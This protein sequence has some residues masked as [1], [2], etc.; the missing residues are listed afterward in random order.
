MR[1]LSLLTS[2]TLLL[3]I[4]AQTNSTGDTISGYPVITSLSLSD[5]PPNSITRYWLL[6]VTQQGSIPI[7]LPVFV[8]RGTNSS[9]T[10]GRKLSLSASIHGDELN[11][12]RVIQ[13]VFANLN[14]T[15]TS[16]DFNGTIIGLPT[17]NPNGNQHNQRNFYSSAANGFLTNLNRVFPGEDPLLD[18]TAITDSYAYV[19]WNALWG[20]TTNVDIAV[21]MH[22]LTT[23]DD[24][25]LWCYAD[26]RL[27]GV[28]RLAELV[29]PD[30]IKIDPGEPGSIET[31]F[32]DNSIPAITLEM[33]APK[34]W[35]NSLIDRAEAFVYRLMDDLSMNPNAS[36]PEVDLSETYKGT[37]FSNI[38]VKQTGW[39]NVSVA[40]LE[41]VAAGQEVG[42]LYNSW[43]DV[44]EV[45]TSSVAGRVSQVRSDP[46]VEQ[47]TRVVQLVYNATEDEAVVGARRMSRR[48]M[49]RAG[50]W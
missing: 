45:L 5:V 12:I 17:V 22:T 8:A 43:G 9:L 15:V 23:D 31:T 21:D 46:A 14:S 2:L 42:T 18:G 38:Y 10:T 6:T 16:G 37:N 28:Q 35:D 1:L 7:F 48:G 27:D 39:L 40:V 32:V 47:G 11:G 30:I 34:R 33:G 25:A 49:E 41:D 26:F 36:K 13:Q 4:L 44:L 29:Q 20:N 50:W 19:I 3:P 24:G